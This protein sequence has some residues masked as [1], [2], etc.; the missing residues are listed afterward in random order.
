MDT[1]IE[2]F[3]KVCEYGSIGKAARSLHVTPQAVSKAINGFEEKL[4]YTREQHMAQGE[5]D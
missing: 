5:D 4:G 2:Y 1:Q 3:L